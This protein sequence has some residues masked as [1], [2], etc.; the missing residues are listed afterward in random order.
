MKGHQIQSE[1]C[2]FFT[3]MNKSQTRWPQ[4]YSQLGASPQKEST[5]APVMF[6]IVK[7]TKDWKLKKIAHSFKFQ[8]FTLS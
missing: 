6:L 1:K 3:Q 7:V 8:H 4:I 2:D 5:F